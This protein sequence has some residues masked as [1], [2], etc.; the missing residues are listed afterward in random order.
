[1]SWPRDLGER[2]TVRLAEQRSI[3]MTRLANRTFATNPSRLD[4]MAMAILVRAVGSD[5]DV[6][7]EL[8]HGEVG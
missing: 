2:V 7:P 4:R 1:M 5:D 6:D 8:D 3:A